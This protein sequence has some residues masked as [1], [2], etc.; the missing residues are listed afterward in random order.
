MQ[1]VK[2]SQLKEGMVTA[3]PVMI[4][5]GL[6]VVKEGVTLTDSLIARIAFYDIKQVEIEDYHALK[7]SSPESGF[8]PT[9]SRRAANSAL[10]QKFQAD[11]EKAVGDLKDALSAILAK[12]NAPGLKSFYLILRP[13]LADAP[14][15]LQMFEFLHTTRMPGDSIYSHSLN[16]ALISDM[17]GK[18]LKF[19]EED[20]EALAAASL[21]HDI[22]KTK[23]PPE[24]LDKP[25]KY[26][27]EEFDLVKKHPVFGCELLEPY[28]QTDPRI[29]RAALLHHERFDGTGYPNG[30][31]RH[32]MT[33]DDNF[34]QLIAI[35]DV[36][37]AMT[38]TRSY[39]EALC[40]FRVIADFEIEGLSK[41]NP[42]YILTFLERIAYTYQSNRVMLTDGRYARI[43][44][45]NKQFLSRPIVEVKDGIVDL[46]KTPDLR[47]QS[48]L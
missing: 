13:L 33:E 24:I 36:Y 1:T 34:A 3:A 40:P 29:P 47:I 38:A 20:L 7:E 10:F 15:S 42:K 27:S 44:M 23:I 28:G 26:T 5:Q 9:Y 37:D 41:Y 39:R 31:K 16:V 4:K 18:W 2:T 11:Y 17:L 25:G 21:L 43:L 22:G 30:M 32:E 8:L 45:L 48:I 35:A 6:A 14:T 19:S 12:D 46:S